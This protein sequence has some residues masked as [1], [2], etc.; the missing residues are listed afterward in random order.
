MRPIL[1]AKGNPYPFWPS[2]GI[3]PEES[4]KIKGC[5]F[6]TSIPAYLYSCSC[7]SLTMCQ[8]VLVPLELL[9]WMGY[10]VA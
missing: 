1:L 7:T 4:Q 10:R 8:G 2:I 6:P 5:S 9:V 3:V